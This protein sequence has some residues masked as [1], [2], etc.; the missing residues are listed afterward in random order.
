VVGSGR[1]LA[2]PATH[3]ARTSRSSTGIGVPVRCR[4]GARRSARIP[5][6]SQTDQTVLWS[7][8]RGRV[9]DPACSPMRIPRAGTALH[10]HDDGAAS[11]LAPGAV[12]FVAYS[13]LHQIR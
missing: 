5:C 8:V 7:E 4:A 12:S 9:C 13:L 3:H 10:T 6:G 2:L 11:W 1:W